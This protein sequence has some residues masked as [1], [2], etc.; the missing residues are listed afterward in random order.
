MPTVFCWN[1]SNGSAANSTSGADIFTAAHAATL[2]AASSPVGLSNYNNAGAAYG[3]WIGICDLSYSCVQSLPTLAE[4]SAGDIISI[5][6]AGGTFTDK[7]IAQRQADLI[8]AD[9]GRCAARF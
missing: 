2:A 8:T 4:G 3:D 6:G 1:N 5:F 7:Q 9:F